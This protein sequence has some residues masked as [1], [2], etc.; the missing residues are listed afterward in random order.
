MEETQLF[1]TIGK[2]EAKIDRL[3]KSVERLEDSVAKLIHSMETNKGSWRV[4]FSIAAMSAL[5]G[6]VAYKP[7]ELLLGIFK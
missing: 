6:G 4:L 5:L 3:E 2:F 7:M 1:H